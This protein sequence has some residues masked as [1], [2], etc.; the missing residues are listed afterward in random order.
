MAYEI[1]IKKEYEGTSPKSFLKKKIDLPFYMIMKYLKEKRITL[2]GK[3]IK[4]DDKLKE[5]DVIKVWL[6]EIQMR[7]KE[8]KHKRE[9]DLN[10]PIIFEN[11]D[12]MVLNKPSGVIVQG[13]QDHETSLSLHLAFLKRQKGDESDFEYTHAHRTDKETSGL[14]IVAKNLPALR[15]LN[16][17]FRGREIRKRY[18]CLCVGRFEKGEGDVEIYLQRTP[19]GVKG[20]II[21]VETKEKDAKH[22]LSHYKVLDEYTY[23]DLDLTLVEVEIKTGVMH[24]IRA[25]MKY[26]GCP[27]LCDS[28]YGNSYANTK[29]EGI[30]S[31][32]F[33][34]ASHLE[35]SF[36]G[37]EYS[38]DA[39]LS[40]DLQ[41]VLNLLN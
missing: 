15:E 38:F 13:A 33:L 11:E 25:H 31:R 6:D 37:K 21:P 19:E 22:S 12:F 16:E 17:I 5:N 26:L 3:K 34:H 23:D 27:I 1:I 14:L 10:I 7:E 36:K 40:E 32:Q 35:F 28:M 39:E 24:Q 2:N 9:A 41:K 4:Q 20:K 29:F 8:K 30:L 18:K